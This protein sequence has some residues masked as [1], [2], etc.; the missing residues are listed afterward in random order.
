MFNT[1]VLPIL[2]GAAAAS[3]AVS[4]PVIEEVLVTADFHASGLMSTPSSISV[5]SEQVIRDRHAEH[6]EAILNTVPNVSYTKGSSRARFLQMRGVGDLEQFVDPKHF[7]SVGIVID[8]VDMGGLA[9]AAS[10][11]DVQQVEFLRGPQGTRFGTNALAG[12]VHVRTHEPTESLEGY[13]DGGYGNYDSWNVGGA[14][15]GPLGA[16]VL[17]RIAAQRVESDGYIDNKFL[18]R[19]DT[20]G[21]EETT[22]R[23]KLRWLASDRTTLDL[24]ASYFDSSNGYD[25]FSLDN[26][27]DTLSDEPG[28]DDQKIWSVALKG[29]VALS[30]VWSLESVVTYTDSDLTYGFDEDWTFVGLCDGT[31]CDPVLDFFSNTDKYQRDRDQWSMDVRLVS[32]DAGSGRRFVVGLFGQKREENLHR[33]FYGDFFSDYEA[34]RLAL[35]G[36]VSEPLGERWRVTAGL[37]YE[38]FEDDYDDTHG[39]SVSSSDD[40]W[41]GELTLERFIGD[42]TLV[43]GTVSRGT[44]PGGINSEASS[45]LPF[46]QPRLQPFVGERLTFDAEKLMNYEVGLKGTY[47]DQRLSLRTAI[48]YMDRSNAQFESW[49]WDNVNFLWV[50]LLDA[51]SDGENYGLELEAA[52]ALTER[53][54]LFGSIGL[55]DSEFDELTVFD[56]DLDDFTTVGD[57]DQA[58]APNYSFNV[59]ANVSFTNQLRGRFEIEGRDESHFGYYHDGVIDSYEIVNASLSY[60]LGAFDLRLWGRNL[61]DEDYAVHGLYF[62]N[63]PRKGWINENYYQFGEPRV[64]GVSLRYSL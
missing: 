11:F 10:L 63:D 53:V 21:L 38:D 30:D 20:N 57:R 8:D 28:Q 9:N 35:Y 1:L 26:T 25:A 37:R 16:R 43:Y 55:L 64:Y 19:D 46:M 33:E 22:L 39:L 59:G 3:S 4:E 60:R 41:S 13:V 49:M 23:G 44:K 29:D 15:G 61:L 48:F 34:D 56:L 58:K 17:G 32:D 2:I 47:F 52:F 50:G 62:G 40:L 6:L 12:S 5:V 45:N 31:L 7:P 27:R 51:S 18:G 24:T 54:E 14:I 42:S 36:E